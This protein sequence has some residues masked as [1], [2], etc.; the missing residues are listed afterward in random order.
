WPL[1]SMA[2]LAHTLALLAMTVAAVAIELNRTRNSF[3]DQYL[4]CGPAMT[5]A[6]PAL[7]D[8]ELKRNPLLKVVWANATAECMKRVSCVSSSLPRDQAI[9]LMAYSM[10]T[11][12]LYKQFNKAVREAG[13]SPQQYRDN[14]HY[15]AWHFLLTQAL[16]T[17]RVSQGEQCRSVFRGVGNYQ[18]QAKPG[19]IVRFGQF[20]STSLDEAVTYGF[21]TDMVFEVY[22]CHGADIHKFSNKSEQQEVLIPPFETF[23]VTDVT[24]DGKSTRI[25]LS[26]TG[27]SSKYNCEWLG[28]DITEGTT[29]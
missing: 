7:K 4:N 18:F 24:Q 19:D 3:D 8:S 1:P 26:S 29:W 16:A 13:S 28:G 23:K 2:P 21:G 22:T 9:A 10:D 15:K 27:N 25:Q 11:R 5:E 6:L 12:G 14:F 17:L 20:A